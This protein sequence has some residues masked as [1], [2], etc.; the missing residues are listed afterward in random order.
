LL[1]VAVSHLEEL[2]RETDE[3]ALLGLYDPTRMEMTFVGAI[4]SQQPVRYAYDFRGTSS[5]LNAGA[6]GLAILAFLTRA[7]QERVL[8]RPLEAI[9]DRTVVDPQRLR[10][11]LADVHERG[12]SC[13]TGER[14]PGCTGLAAPVR[15]PGGRV[16]GAI[17]LNMPATRFDPSRELALAEAVIRCADAILRELEGPEPR[18]DGRGGLATTTVDISS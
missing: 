6:A 1:Q 3:T 5:P 18:S 9:T 13:T 15:A 11:L 10:E 12:Y 14:T 7:E 4:E 17:V 8:S 2:V 16:L